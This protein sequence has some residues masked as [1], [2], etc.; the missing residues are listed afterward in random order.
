MSP[1]EFLIRGR[2]PGP[3]YCQ[4]PTRAVSPLI[5]MVIVLG[6]TEPVKC[7]LSHLESEEAGHGHMI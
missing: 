7:A 1:D 3:R 5:G 2:G 6:S 4:N